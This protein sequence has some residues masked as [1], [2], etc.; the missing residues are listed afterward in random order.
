VYAAP[1]EYVRAGSWSEAVEYLGEHGDAARV[2]AGGQSLVPMMMLRLLEPAVLVDVRGV[3]RG[4]IERVNGHVV[5]PALT[6]HVDLEESPVVREACPV[7]ADAA[8]CIGNVRVRHRGTIGGSLAHAEPTAELPCVAVALGAR[9]RALGPNGSRTVAASDLFIGYFETSL[10]HHEVITDVELPVLPPRSGA[11]FAELAR[12]AGDFASVEAAGVVVLAADGTCSDV[13]VVVG[14]V[15]DRPL[16]LSDHAA[17]LRGVRPD[18]RAVDEAAR[19]AAA[20]VE[21]GM[22]GHG[23]PEYRRKMLAVIVGRALTGAVA[24]ARAEG[25]A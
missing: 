10:A 15:S 12:R 25:S 3:G 8:A 6:R 1:F 20:A 18:A 14:A 5:V 16:D 9:V 17:S 7:L 4:Q 19:A 2:I 22:G 13:R 23:S 24:R 11:A 21:V